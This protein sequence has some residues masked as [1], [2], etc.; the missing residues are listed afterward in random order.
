METVSFAIGCFMFETPDADLLTLDNPSG[1]YRIQDWAADVKK[2]LESIPSVDNI[3]IVAPTTTH[4]GIQHPGYLPATEDQGDKY[5]NGGPFTPHP[6]NGRVSFRVSIPKH[7]QDQ[8]TYKPFGMAS[9]KFA[10]E[11]SFNALFPVTFIVMDQPED[12]PAHAVVVVREFLRAEFRQRADKVGGVRFACLGPSPMWVDCWAAVGD[13]TSAPSDQVTAYHVASE[14]YDEFTFKAGAPD[15]WQAYELVKRE[16]ENEVGLFYSLIADRNLLNEQNA[17]IDA[18]L[19]ALVA[20]QES[21]GL[22]AWF[23]RLRLSGRDS[24]SLSLQVLEAQRF[25]SSFLSSYREE[26]ENHYVLHPL[27]PFRGLIER[28]LARQVA[29]R[30][31]E[32]RE[33]VAILSASHAHSVQVVSVVASS[34]GGGIVGAAIAALAAGAGS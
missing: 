15:V 16:V 27:A 4:G 20:L 28:E 25:A 11:I 8:V 24:T 34:L 21:S 29:D 18:Q 14:G 12:Q 1:T 26:L 9:T 32:V 22:R 33:M 23:R 7:V 17:F 31:D 10:V 13:E 6:G 5:H 3:E 30:R 2:A 19:S